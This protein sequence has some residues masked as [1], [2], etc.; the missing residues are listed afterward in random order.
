MAQMWAAKGSTEAVSLRLEGVAVEASI[1][2]FV[3]MPLGL[4]SSWA[5][6][7]LPRSLCLVTSRSCNRTVD[8]VVMVEAC[9]V[10]DDEGGGQEGEVRDADYYR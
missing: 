1:E 4:W 10:D 6:V 2:L 9:D 3:F 5:V 7:F 8:P